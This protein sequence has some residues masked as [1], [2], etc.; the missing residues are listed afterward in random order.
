MQKTS[1]LWFYAGVF[2]LCMSTLMLQIVQTRILSVMSFY[3]LAFLSIGLAMFGLTSGALLVYFD[4]FGLSGRP[5]AKNLTW[6][7]SAYA[8]SIAL[9]FAVQLTSV[10]C[11][12][13]SATFL[14]MWLKLV[15]IISIPFV[16]AGMAVSLALTRS[17]FP[18]AVV[19][20]VDLVG[21][22]SGCLA[23][24]LLLDVMDAP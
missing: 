14:L 1:C 23:V 21:A 3:Y 20:S 6:V 2:F 5:F 12:V 15:V 18:I 11:L 19:Y 22:A 13:G 8:V 24:L 4:K 16:F 17:P 9:C 10:T 7:T